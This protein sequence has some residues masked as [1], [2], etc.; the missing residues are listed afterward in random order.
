MTK[1]HDSDV[2]HYAGLA[3]FSEATAR[4]PIGAPK[5]RHEAIC[6]RVFLGTPSFDIPIKD[7]RAVFLAV[8]QDEYLRTAGSAYRRAICVDVSLY[9]AISTPMMMSTLTTPHSRTLPKKRWRIWEGAF[10][11]LSAYGCSILVRIKP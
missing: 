9:P 6:A 5:P 4:L 7:L 2:L 8:A 10:F 11:N 1:N 3:P